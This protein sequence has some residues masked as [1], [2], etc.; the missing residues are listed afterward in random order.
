LHPPQRKIAVKDADGG[1]HVA[2]A[3]GA[4]PGKP[5]AVEVVPEVF[6]LISGPLKVHF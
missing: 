6:E 5:A 1:V 2:A 3:L 4:G